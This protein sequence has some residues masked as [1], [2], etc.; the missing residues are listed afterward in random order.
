MEKTGFDWR[1]FLR[2]YGVSQ[3]YRVKRNLVFITSIIRAF[4]RPA[5]FWV[6]AAIINGPIAAHDF[7]GTLFGTLGF[8][9]LLASTASVL[10]LRSRHQNQ[11]G[12]CLIH[13]LR[14]ALFDNLQRQPLSFFH[15]TKQGRIL[16]YVVSDLE[17]V[18]RGAQLLVFIA[19]EFVQLAFGAVLMAYY[20][21]ALFLVILAFVPVLIWANHY[22]HP[23]LHRL[24]RNAAESSSRLTSA[25]AESLRGMRVIQSFS[26]Q[27]RGLADFTTRVKGVADDNVCLATESAL[28]APLLG[29]TGQFFLAALL[30]VGGWCV[31][32]GVAGMDIESLVAFF[33]LP[34][35]FFLSVQ[36]A[37][38]YYPGILASQVGVERVFA[39]ID[40]VPASADHPAAVELIRRS[41]QEVRGLAVAFE[42]VSFGYEPGRLVVHEISFLAE[43]G[44]TVAL[45]G[46]TGSGKSTLVNLVAKFYEPEAGRILIEGQDSRRLT[47]AS[48]R[49]Q[50]GIV[51]QNNF[52]FSG[53]VLENL[54]FGRPEAS[55]EEVRRAA[56][57][58]DCLDLLESLPQ[59]LAT[60]VGENGTQLSAGQRQLVCFTRALLADPAILI[61]DEATSAVDPVTEFRIQAALR[62][63][64]HGRTSFVVA[65][66]LSTILEAD[67][68]LVLQNGRLAESGTHRE[69]LRQRGTYRALYRTF[70]LGGL[71]ATGD[72]TSAVP[73]ASPKSK[74]QNA[75]AT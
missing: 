18:R 38:S 61:L 25:L 14:N 65:H 43:R 36:A 71:T 42:N 52:L 58:L 60:V 40:H 15:K 10:H 35:S 30:V 6:I 74:P 55:D 66:R 20:N 50:L 34:T 28:Y 32:H 68:I 75:F 12:E 1:L 17:A 47:A 41:D 33:F 56:A 13:D 57:Q 46:H 5:Q 19:Q 51:H 8:L 22:F 21:W 63:L 59:G 11:L 70:I 45:V 3:P 2:L 31:L 4:Q 27:G 54:R 44:K 49:R 26:G 67:Q 29:L 16:S 73:A 39:A 7:H 72:G 23:R 24:S 62:R 9:A 48:V 69:L 37:A 53:T 64:L